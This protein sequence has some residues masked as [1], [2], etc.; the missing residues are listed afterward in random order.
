MQNK[1]LQ[2][3][4][5]LKRLKAARKEAGLRQE[6][7]ANKLGKYVSY[8]SKIETGTRR[9]DVMEFIELMKIYNKPFEYFV[10]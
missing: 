9:I 6:V 1:E 5:L 8:I 3:K 7:V 2:Y 10:S 4:T